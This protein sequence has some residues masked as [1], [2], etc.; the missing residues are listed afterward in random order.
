MQKEKQKE[1]ELL[2]I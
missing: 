2:F 1:Q